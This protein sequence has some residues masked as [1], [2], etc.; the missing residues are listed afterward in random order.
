M[1]PEDYEKEK[2]EAYFRDKFKPQKS[3]E[4]AVP[5][6]SIAETPELREMVQYL[7][8]N[9]GYPVGMGNTISDD[10]ADL[11]IDMV[12]KYDKEQ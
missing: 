1:T 10:Q 3:S 4:S 8:S 11:L 7:I 6:G 5:A 9:L 12:R 2:A